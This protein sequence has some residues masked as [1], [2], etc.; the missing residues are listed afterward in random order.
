M[1]KRRVSGAYQGHFALTEE[2]ASY[3]PELKLDFSCVVEQESP[4]LAGFQ[5]PSLNVVC[6][7][8]PTGHSSRGSS[9][10]S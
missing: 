6:S 7:G 1:Q 3:P 9:K 5:A 8:C 10:R 4:I 2:E